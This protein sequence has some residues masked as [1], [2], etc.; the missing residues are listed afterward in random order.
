MRTN[1][2]KKTTGKCGTKPDNMASLCRA[3]RCSL[4]KQVANLERALEE[5]SCGCMASKKLSKA[6]DRESIPNLIFVSELGGQ[7]AQAMTCAMQ[8][9]SGRRI[10]LGNDGDDWATGSAE[11][12]CAHT[13]PNTNSPEDCNEPSIQA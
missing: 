8:H 10:I 2:I 5:S 6:H 13:R 1:G 9:K 11:I 4:P 12:I 3:R 7:R